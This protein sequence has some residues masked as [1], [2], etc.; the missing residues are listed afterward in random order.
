MQSIFKPILWCFVFFLTIPSFLK[1]Q[2][3]YLYHIGLADSIQ[4]TILLENRAF[5]VHL[6]DSYNPENGV[7]YPVLYVLDGSV[8]LSGIAS[9]LSYQSPAY[10]PEMIVVGIANNQHRTRDLT[11]SKV[12]IR[13]GFQVGESGEADQFIA[14]IGEE[15]IPYI[16]QKYKTTPYRTLIGH[17]FG[18][19]FA[20]NTWMKHGDWFENYLAIDPSLDWDNQKLLNEIKAILPQKDFE[21]KALFVSIANDFG[22]FNANL[23]LYNLM[24]DTT[25]FSL[26][27]RSSFDLIHHIEKQKKTDLRFYWKYYDHQIHGTVPLISIY[28]GLRTMFSW[29]QLEHAPKF[30]DFE[31]PIAEIVQLI[32]E[33]EK[34]LLKHFGY[35]TP[36]FE[37]GLLDMLGDMSLDM[38]KEAKA[39]AIFELNVEYYPNSPQVYHKM[40]TY[41]ITQD[42]NLEAIKYLQKAHQLSQEDQYL[43]QIKQ[44]QS[45]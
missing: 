22:R 19:L 38:G 25:E 21:G 4:S 20:I 18:G 35:K 27:E 11:P 17:S 8:H 16:D 23:N 40:A 28:D 10:I 43:E 34:K 1:A 15:L 14:F 7:H 9:I 44:L 37:E 45:K 12:A 5:W 33:R 26:P 6:P 13:R 29:Y 39:K 2:E 30:N 24:M 31:T 36:P 41:F 32:R 3:G 42:N